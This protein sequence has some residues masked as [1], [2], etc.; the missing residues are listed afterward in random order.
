MAKQ[1][2]RFNEKNVMAKL[3]MHGL[4]TWK[5]KIRNRNIYIYLYIA[6]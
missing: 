3:Y 2:K 4:T 1:R 6:Y 5:T